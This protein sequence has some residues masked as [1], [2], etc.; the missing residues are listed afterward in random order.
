MPVTSGPGLL[1]LDL[2]VNIR[3]PGSRAHGIQV[4]AMA[5]ALA[6]TGLVVDVVVPRR[7]PY[8]DVDPWQ[9][10]GVKRT[11]RVHRIAS[12][13]TIDLVPPALQRWPFLVQ[14]VSYAWRALARAAVTR[15]SG[16]L[17]RDHYTLDVL[18]H[19]LRGRDLSRLAV[20]IHDL[21]DSGARRRRLMRLL[22][23]I[24]AV[25]TISDALRD[26]LIAEGLAA[27]K[28]LVA[29]DGVHLGRF[30]DLPDAETA[31]AHLGLPGEKT[32]VYAGQLYPW[33]GVDM[34]VVALGR[35]PDAR[36]LIVG[37]DR[38]HLPRVRELAAAH[39]PGRVHF[40]GQVPHADVPFHLAAGDALV[41]PNSAQ[42]TISAR[43]TS[44]LKLFEGMAT[45][46]PLVASSL[47]SLREVLTHDVNAWLVEPDDAAALADGLT[48]V[49]EDEPL[50][51]RLSTRARE[52]VAPYDWSER[53]KLVARW[54][55]EKLHTGTAA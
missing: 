55:R 25:I 34:L 1:H 5:E 41:L 30:A 31:R 42:Q 32:I 22:R 18:V 10:Y 20:E 50:A 43:Y 48:R 33:K 27:D 24:P 52:D 11:F 28:L 2:M 46:R 15:S 51:R 29:R 37:G 26:D 49:L 45:G 16:V 36:L 39:A 23:R 7:F 40:A 19:G 47:P 35:M 8:Q 3:F 14:S 44:P 13:D 53:G 6:A 38:T 17:V 54:L 4:A 12:L 9:H 21:P